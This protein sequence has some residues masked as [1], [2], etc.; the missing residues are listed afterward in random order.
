[1]C[2]SIGTCRAVWVP[3]QDLATPHLLHNC[4]KHILSLHCTL[5]VHLCTY[6]YA[7][8]R[9][10]RVFASSP[11]CMSSL[12][13]IWNNS[14]N[15][16]VCSGLQGAYVFFWGLVGYSTPQF[17]WIMFVFAV[18]RVQLL[19][20]W[21][22]VNTFVVLKYVLTFHSILSSDIS[23]TFLAAPPQK[24]VLQLKAMQA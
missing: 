4:G 23:A 14:G 2:S 22:I 19:I 9:W 6:N 20:N 16:W 12:H 10:P 7:I 13:M 5:Y 3:G 21:S 24:A 8:C 15:A 18:M 1:M 11:H 17:C